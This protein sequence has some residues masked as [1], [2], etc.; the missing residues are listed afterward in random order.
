MKKSYGMPVFYVNTTNSIIA[1]K[2]DRD[3]SK[4]NRT[5]ENARKRVRRRQRHLT[6][7]ID[8]LIWIL[9]AYV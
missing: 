1:V 9:I 6:V 8:D 7:D 2:P 4:N 5:I 3:G